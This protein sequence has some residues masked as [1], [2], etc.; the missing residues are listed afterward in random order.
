MTDEKL[1]ISG[2]LSKYSKKQLKAKNIKKSSTSN[3]RPKKC[4]M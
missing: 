3:T 2:S 1:D 4:T